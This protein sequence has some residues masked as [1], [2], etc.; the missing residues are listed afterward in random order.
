[1][2]LVLYRIRHKAMTRV[3]LLQSNPSAQPII[4]ARVGTFG[5]NMHDFRSGLAASRRGLRQPSWSCQSCYCMVSYRF[6]YNPRYHQACQDRSFSTLSAPRRA[7]ALKSNKQP[8]C[9]NLDPMQ[10]ISLWRT[11][12]KLFVADSPLARQEIA[13]RSPLPHRHQQRNSHATSVA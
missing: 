11:G 2:E 12:A 13:P 4:D 10:L 6:S 8:R 9:I 3:C 5:N 7:I 1:M